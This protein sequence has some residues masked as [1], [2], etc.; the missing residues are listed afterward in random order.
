[1]SRD[2]FKYILAAAV[3]KYKYDGKEFYFFFVVTHTIIIINNNQSAIAINRAKG[4]KIK[5]LKI[6]HIWLAVLCILCI[7]INTSYFLPF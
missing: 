1:M 7:K 3:Y 4:N 6:L 2:Q 5:M